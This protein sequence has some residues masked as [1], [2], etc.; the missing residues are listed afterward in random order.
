MG[1]GDGKWWLDR[2]EQIRGLNGREVGGV[3][4]LWLE[5]GQYWDTKWYCSEME[6]GMKM[7]MLMW[8]WLNRK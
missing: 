1:C 8:W 2:C 3:L 5:G 4:G 7:G 6:M